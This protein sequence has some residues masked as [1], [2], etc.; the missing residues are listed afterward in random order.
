M[1]TRV[2]AAAKKAA[3]AKAAAEDRKADEQADQPHLP[4]LHQRLLRLRLRVLRTR[5]HRRGNQ[6][7]E[8]SGLA[9]KIEDLEMTIK[10]LRE[11]SADLHDET[12]ER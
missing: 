3:E 2:V 10:A 12:A 8:Q 11:A 4:Q 9:A 7:H 1:Q 6:D 5:W